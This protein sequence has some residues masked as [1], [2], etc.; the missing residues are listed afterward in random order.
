MNDCGVKSLPVSPPLPQ[1]G[2]VKG[3][4]DFSLWQSTEDGLHKKD[5]L[6]YSSLNNNNNSCF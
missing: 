3:Q 2:G 4:G 5:I 6:K 1:P